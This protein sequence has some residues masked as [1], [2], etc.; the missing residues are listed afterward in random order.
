LERIASYRII[1]WRRSF[2]KRVGECL[3]LSGFILCEGFVLGLFFL[4][5]SGECLER[6]KDFDGREDDYLV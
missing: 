1:L 5:L 2:I 4:L 3:R 6:F